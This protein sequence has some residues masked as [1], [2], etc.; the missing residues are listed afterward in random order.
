VARQL[1][2]W[3]SLRPNL[4]AELESREKWS[5]LVEIA[6]DETDIPRALELLP[7]IRWG[8]YD[9]R[10][11]QAAEAAYPQDSIRIYCRHIEQLIAARGRENYRT[12]AQLLVKV[13]NLY[14]KLDEQD[15][16][17]QYLIHIRLDNSNLPA[18]QDELNKASLP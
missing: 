4:L 11:A 6:L 10:V 13:K 5:D 15:T 17:Q 1:E 3:E 12:A 7:K 8:Q 18:L 9:L 16:W 14:Q 2:Q